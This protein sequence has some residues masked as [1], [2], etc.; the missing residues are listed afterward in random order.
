MLCFNIVRTMMELAGS[1]GD[2]FDDDDD[3]DASGVEN[4]PTPPESP[5]GGK[6]DVASVG[7]Q[8][9]GTREKEEG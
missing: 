3:S 8:N 5:G 9:E 6:T 1:D 2:V 4:A 7:N